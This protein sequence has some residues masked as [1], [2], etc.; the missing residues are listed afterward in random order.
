M[1]SAF[2]IKTADG[3]Y[4]TAEVDAQV[5]KSVEHLSSLGMRKGYHLALILDI[6]PESVALLLASIRLGLRVFICP[7]REPCGAIK[8]WLK[9]FGLRRALTS[10]EDICSGINGAAAGFFCKGSEADGFSTV[11][12]TSGT[13]GTP[14]NALIPLSAHV[15]SAKS[16]NAYFSF[17]HESCWALSLPLYHVSGLSIIFRALLARASIFVARDREEL[18]ASIVEK[19]ISHLSVVP[20]Q[21][22]RLLE[23]GVDL[24]HLNAIVIGGDGISEGLSARIKE[25]GLPAF[26]TYGLTETASMVAIKDLRR[27]ASIDIL[28]H[29]KMTIGDDRE[30]RVRGGS[31]FCGYLDGS[32]ELYGLD[33]D[34][35][36]ATGDIANGQDPYRLRIVGRTDNRII[37]GGEN[38]QAEEI[39]AVLESHPHI[40]LSVVVGV[41][42]PLFGMRP[43]AY[44][45]WRGHPLG[46]REL[47]EH[48]RGSLAPYKI[49]SRFHL[50]PE[51]LQ[52]GLKKPRFLIQRLAQED[53]R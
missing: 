30:I 13:T 36:F 32:G 3:V 1:K 4:S 47:V 6:S 21:L 12:R 51:S 18:Q 10:R 42:D 39:E 37:S 22:H 7:S 49:P 52:D 31:L 53:L 5:L 34:G 46:D 43:H 41:M 25:L 40:L 16:V 29:V 23:M 24:S 35:F 9:V 28:P 27:D 15:A 11:L 45:K 2:N 26:A 38:I 20:T 44:I 19:R 14:K 48:L 33:P 50:W 8:E 17:D